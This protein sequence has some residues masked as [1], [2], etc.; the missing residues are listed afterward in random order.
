M[1]QVRIVHPGGPACLM[2]VYVGPAQLLAVNKVEIL[3]DCDDN[4][5][6]GARLT[7]Y[8][9][10]LDI[11]AEADAEDV[12][13]IPLDGQPDNGVDDLHFPTAGFYAPHYRRELPAAEPPAIKP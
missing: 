8:D 5:P 13:T 1:A 4:K 11:I 3:M 6:V 10:D 9:V 2:R 12:Q 7:I